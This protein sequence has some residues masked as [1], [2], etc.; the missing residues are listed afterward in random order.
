M[1]YKISGCTS[2]KQEPA[3]C[4]YGLWAA[5]SRS[6]DGLES[7]CNKVVQLNSTAARDR[8]Y[9]VAPCRFCQSEISQA[10][11]HAQPSA[12]SRALSL[13][14]RG[15]PPLPSVFKDHR[16][17][18]QYLLPTPHI[19]GQISSHPQKSLQCQSSTTSRRPPLPSTQKAI[20]P[21]N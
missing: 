8:H 17:A 11:Q 3:L 21:P 14:A 13:V 16:E 9:Y 12:T 6:R 7:A 15:T 4:L 10:L 20:R 18:L 1:I 19:G 2:S 5:S